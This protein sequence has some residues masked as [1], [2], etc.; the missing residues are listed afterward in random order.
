[1]EA[2]DDLRMI[3]NT[4]DYAMVFVD[5]ISTLDNAK[6]SNN[7]ILKERSGDINSHPHREETQDI[8]LRSH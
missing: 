8:S 1:M 2:H 5:V 6:S 3:H 7:L 4:M